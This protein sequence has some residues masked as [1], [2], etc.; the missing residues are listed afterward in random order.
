MIMIIATEHTS[1]D[2]YVGRKEVDINHYN[3]SRNTCLSNMII[4]NLSHE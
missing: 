2:D 1:H 3:Y 4:R